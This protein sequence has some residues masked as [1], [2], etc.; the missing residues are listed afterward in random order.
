MWRLPR[1]M[2]QGLFYAY[3]P[4]CAFHQIRDTN[5]KKTKNN[6]DIENKRSDVLSK[7]NCNW[8]VW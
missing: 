2:D 8:L 1:D 3:L 4:T 6:S 7:V 5:Q